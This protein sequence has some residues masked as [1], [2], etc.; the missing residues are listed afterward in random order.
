MLR[1][2]PSARSQRPSESSAERADSYYRGY[3]VHGG[4]SP[5]AIGSGGDEDLH[6]SLGLSQQQ[7]P[8]HGHSSGIVRYC[9]LAIVFLGLSVHTFSQ[10]RTYRT[11]L[12]RLDATRHLPLDLDE[13]PDDR[14]LHAEL[15]T[16]SEARLHLQQSLSDYTDRSIPELRAE[17]DAIQ[18]QIDLVIE[19]TAVKN[20]ELS[21][22]RTRRT[23]LE[24]WKQ[25][26]EEREGLVWEKMDG[27]EQILKDQRRWEVEQW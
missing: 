9:L 23:K 14:Q 15:R 6:Y 5:M 26:M 27:L 25:L 10:Y 22:L 18:R 19:D 16:L 24:D 21:E 17:M 12:R 2:R 8:L 1:S 7:R 3:P 20:G 4:A 13:E 11:L